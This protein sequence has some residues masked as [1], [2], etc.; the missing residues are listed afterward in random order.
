MDA[1]IA[2][3]SAAYSSIGTHAILTIHFFH[4]GTL[5]SPRARTSL[6]TATRTRSWYRIARCNS[7][8]SAMLELVRRMRCVPRRP[9]FL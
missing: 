1:H 8:W 6:Y 2:S 3:T 4:H 7:A 9:F 5:L